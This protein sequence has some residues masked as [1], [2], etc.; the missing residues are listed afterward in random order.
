MQSSQADQMEAVGIP[1]PL[2][3]VQSDC[4]GRFGDDT[5]RFVFT[6]I[7]PAQRLNYI[8]TLVKIIAV[9]GIILMQI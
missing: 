4:S 8:A 1:L 6:K 5:H 3:D 7:R 2:E 9:L